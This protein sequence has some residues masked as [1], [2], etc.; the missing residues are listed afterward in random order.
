MEM[1]TLATGASRRLSLTKKS[2]K[3]PFKTVSVENIGT[4]L[5]EFQGAY[6]SQ[7]FADRLPVQALGPLL[8]PRRSRTANSSP[9]SGPVPVYSIQYIV[10]SILYI[11]YRIRIPHTVYYCGVVT[12][13]HGVEEVPGL[14]AMAPTI[15]P[16]LP[17]H[18]RALGNS[19]TPMSY[20]LCLICRLLPMNEVQILEAISYK[21]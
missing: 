2:K 15:L 12:R 1:L 9:K 11:G 14:V 7:L 10:Y 19:Q 4:A 20:V 6:A 16:E 17:K 21:L 5:Q 13:H 8:G 3:G 18:S